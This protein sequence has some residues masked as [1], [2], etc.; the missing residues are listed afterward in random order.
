MAWTT[1]VER[2]WFTRNTAAD[3]GPLIPFQSPHAPL[4]S[5]GTEDGAYT[6]GGGPVVDPAAVAV[7]GG[8]Q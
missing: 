1:S 8:A 5:G 3:C 2:L 7:G 6:G 4:T